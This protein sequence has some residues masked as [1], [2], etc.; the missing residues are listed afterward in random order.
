[1]VCCVCGDQREGYA[2]WYEEL[3][4][5]LISVSRA[6]VESIGSDLCFIKG[7]NMNERKRETLMLITPSCDH[8]AQ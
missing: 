2:R 8:S 6:L 7:R 3:Y 1:M 4:G 5:R